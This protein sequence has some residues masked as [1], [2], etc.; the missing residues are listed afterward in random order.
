MRSTRMVIFDYPIFFADEKFFTFLDKCLPLSLK[1]YTFVRQIFIIFDSMKKILLAILVCLGVVLF[2]ESDND[3]GITDLSDKTVLEKTK[4]LSDDVSEGSNEVKK[5]AVFSKC[6][7]YDSKLS[8]VASDVQFIP[9]ADEPLIGEHT[10]DIALSDDFIFLLGM[11]HIYQYDK[12]GRFIRKIGERGMGPRDY[13]NLCPPLQ[14]NDKEKSIY[15]LDLNRRRVVVYNLDGTFNRAFN[16]NFLGSMAILDSTTIAVREGF[17]NYFMPNVPLLHFM[18][19]NGE[20]NKTFY[21]HLHPVISRKEAKIIPDINILW[22]HAGKFYHI[23]D[24]ADTVFRISRDSLVPVW[25]LT[26]EFKRN[27]KELYNP[28]DRQKKLLSTVTFLPNSGVFESNKFLIFRL[29]DSQ[30]SYYMVYDKT[31]GKFHSTFDNK[32]PGV[33]RLVHPRGDT[34]TAKEMDFFI[35]DLVSGLHFTPRYQSMGKAIALISAITVTEKR[36]EI[37]RHIASH[38]SEESARLK[39][40]VEKMDEFDN[41]LVMIVT[42]K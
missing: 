37:L 25:I 3:K 8:T 23:E 33:E 41:P 34:R 13:I 39:T 14:I 24:G 29:I 12:Q 21:S 16:T 9:L 18:N 20:N 28:L 7:N 31:S 32:V 27:K 22:E 35:D 1:Q 30:D 38:P 26:G 5:I 10:I 2:A 19:H 11:S 40:M 15:A 17:I 4:N 6:T 42:F 36:D